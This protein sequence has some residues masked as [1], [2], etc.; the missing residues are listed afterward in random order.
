MRAG[1]AK[2]TTKINSWVFR[3]K[4]K[5]TMTLAKL[6]PQLLFFL[7]LLLNIGIYFTAKFTEPADRIFAECARNSGRTAAAINL[8]LLFLIGH[9][10]LKKIYSEEVKLK[11]FKLLISLFAVNHLIHFIF[12]YQN[13]NWHGMKLGIYDNLHGVITYITL[14]MLPILVYSFNRLNAFLYY[15][16][17]VHFFNVTYFIAISFYGRYKPGIDEAYLHRIGVLIMILALFYILYR[18]FEERSKEIPV[19]INV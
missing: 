11:F 15:L 6:K 17:I 3:L 16:L 10:G 18:V 14:I 1:P 5:L 9:F 8:I 12:L 13:F 4:I 2:K 7:I 19:N